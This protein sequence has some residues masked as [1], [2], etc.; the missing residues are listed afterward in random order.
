MNVTCT[1]EVAAVLSAE[2]AK[3]SLSLSLP[4]SLSPRLA[5]SLS[6]SLALWRA[7]FRGLAGSIWPVV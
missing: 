2:S 1:S 7:V 4:L 3:L 6:P 5:L